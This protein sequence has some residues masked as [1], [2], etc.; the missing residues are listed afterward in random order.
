LFH[1]TGVMQH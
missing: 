1:T